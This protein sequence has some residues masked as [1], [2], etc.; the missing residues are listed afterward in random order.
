MERWVPTLERARLAFAYRGRVRGHF[1][2]VHPGAN[3]LKKSFRV[4]LG[5]API[6]SGKSAKVGQCFKNRD[7]RWKISVLWQVAYHCSI[8]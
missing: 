7:T 3:Q 2:Y 4:F 1:G 5:V 8:R 6:H